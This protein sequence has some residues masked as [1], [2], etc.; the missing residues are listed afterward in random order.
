[1]SRLST[2]L[3]LT[4]FLIASVDAVGS[5]LSQDHDNVAEQG[6]ASSQ[7]AQAGRKAYIDPQTGELTS[8]PPL[9]SKK[10]KAAITPNLQKARQDV[11]MVTHPDGEVSADIRGLFM[12]TLEAEIVDGKLVTCH[13]KSGQRDQQ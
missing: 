7:P 13:K 2:L 9:T 1:V 12:S 10:P 4:G 6:A 8:S 5:C 11:P 3:L